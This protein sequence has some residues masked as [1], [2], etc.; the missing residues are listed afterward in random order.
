MN[1]HNFSEEEAE[2]ILARERQRRE[3]ANERREHE[4]YTGE[5][6]PNDADGVITMRDLQ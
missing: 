3:L 1:L 5:R 4:Y 6:E 2:E